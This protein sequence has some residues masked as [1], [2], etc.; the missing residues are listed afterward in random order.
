MYETES[1]R[2]H[3]LEITQFLSEIWGCTFVKTPAAYS[4]DFVMMRKG[5]A[6]GMCEIKDRSKHYDTLML[7]LHK[8]VDAL[9]YAQVLD[10]PFLI[11]ARTPE[12][13]FWVNVMEIEVDT[14]VGGRND[15]GD[16][17]DMEPV[18]YLPY[19]KMKKIKG[20]EN[21]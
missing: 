21:D 2:S 16:E 15:R 17:Q 14:G 5:R 18:V 1:D 10:F 19:S 3:E 8:W 9:R 4:F 11:I 7:S 12:G 20:A 13:I 6:V